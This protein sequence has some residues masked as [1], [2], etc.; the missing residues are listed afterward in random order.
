MVVLLREMVDT[1]ERSLADLGRR[2]LDVAQRDY[3]LPWTL[4]QT[5]PGTGP[6]AAV[7]LLAE[8]GDDT[9]AFGTARRLA[10][11]ALAARTGVRVRA[12]DV[13]AVGGRILSRG[14]P[15]SPSARCNGVNTDATR[16]NRKRKS[17]QPSTS[18]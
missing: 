15:S 13:R 7:A 4:L 16:R 12:R 5:L 11:C 9:E 18:S 8:V 17:N 3:E 14:Q 6:L 10:N 1:V 2:I